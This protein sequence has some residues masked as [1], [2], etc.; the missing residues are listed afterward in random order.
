MLILPRA[1]AAFTFALLSLIA[2]AK[3]DPATA[4]ATQPSL[5]TAADV[6]VKYYLSLPKGWNVAKTWP[7]VVTLDGS[8]H[9]F[10]G[11]CKAFMAARGERPFIL[12]TP[13]V[14]SN[15]NDPADQKAVLAIIS[16]VRKA[17]HGQEK[18]FLTGFSAGGHCTWQI[19]YTHPEIL[20]GVALAAA[21]FRGRGLHAFSDSPSRAD[22]PIH[23]FQGDKDAFV[24]PLNEQWKDAEKA[25]AEH[26][27]KN[28]KHTVVPGA[29]HQAFAKQVL[30]YF[31]TLLSRKDS[32]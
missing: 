13:C 2:I 7:I 3:A 21:N 10:L 29:T 6:P 31:E 27:Y 8:G 16:E 9:N 23:A 12:V 24:L 14:S 1:L 17:H 32:K 20:A 5:V 18:V 25:A 22:L 28:L 4:P 30:D 26:G 19:T 11:N 15:G